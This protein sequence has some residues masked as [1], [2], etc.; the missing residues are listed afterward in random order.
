MAFFRIFIYIDT[1]SPHQKEKSH[2]GRAGTPGSG[3]CGVRTSHRSTADHSR[4][5]RN[6]RFPPGA[7]A[8]HTAARLTQEGR[9]LR[10]DF[11]RTVYRAHC[12]H[13]Q[14]P[15][16]PRSG[17]AVRLGVPVRDPAA[18]LSAPGASGPLRNPLSRGAWQNGTPPD[19]ELPEKFRG[20]YAKLP[21]MDPEQEKQLLLL[22]NSAPTGYFTAFAPGGCWRTPRTS[23]ARGSATFCNRA[24]P[25][26]SDCRILRRSWNSPAPHT[27]VLVKQLFGCS[28][29]PRC[30]SA[31]GWRRR[32]TTLAGTELRL[33][34]DRRTV[35]FFQRIPLKQGVQRAYRPCPGRLA[36]AVDTKH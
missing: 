17:G 36:K 28:P 3:T 24:W 30:C 27:S 31:Y 7:A 18:G 23:A 25:N 35:R 29:S 6:F 13:R 14:T 9:R 5:G 10:G 19:A 11:Q 12:R 34:P 4:T 21:P 33:Q 2:D 20:E 8:V 15:A 16:L 26:R 1:V 22:E 32:G